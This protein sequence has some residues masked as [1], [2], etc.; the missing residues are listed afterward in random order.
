MRFVT[1]G[2]EVEVPDDIDNRRVI[3]CL[4]IA[5]NYGLETIAL[6][7][8]DPAIDSPEHLKTARDLDSMDIGEFI[9]V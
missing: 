7:L 2:F 3:E 4:D 5:M 8:N 9:L 6:D 1:I